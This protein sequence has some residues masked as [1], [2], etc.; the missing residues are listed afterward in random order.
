MDRGRQ[1]WLLNELQRLLEEQTD[2][3]RQGKLYEV[4]RLGGQASNI[5]EEI[6]RV[7]ILEATEFHE[8]RR[9]LAE[10]YRELRLTLSDQRDEVGRE[11]NRIRKG[12]KTIGVYRKSIQTAR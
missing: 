4:E 9:K 7:G 10:A 6:A 2:L 12:K 1:I 3:A 8:Q 11:L 5:V